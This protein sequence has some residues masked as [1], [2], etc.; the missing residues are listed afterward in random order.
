MYNNYSSNNKSIYH[1]EVEIEETNL[2]IRI[3]RLLKKEYTK[4]E[5][6]T[7]NNRNK[8][9]FMNQNKS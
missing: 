4:K 6:W 5:N 1:L 8:T 3:F 7:K 9:K 2:I